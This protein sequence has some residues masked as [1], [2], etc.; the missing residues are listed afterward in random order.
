MIVLHQRR[1]QHGE[2]AAELERLGG[3][4]MMLFVTEPAS[5]RELSAIVR[6][7]DSTIL[8]RASLSAGS[9]PAITPRVA[10]RALVRARDPR[11][12]GRRTGRTPATRAAPTARTR[13]ERDRA[14]R[15]R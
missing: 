8:L 11:L 1:C 9:Y 5:G 14:P 13:T 10:A 3:R 6:R 2:I 7:S 15:R 12:V 4:L